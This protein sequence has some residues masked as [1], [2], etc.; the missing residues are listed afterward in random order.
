MIIKQY[1]DDGMEVRII[2]IKDKKGPK[3]TK[4][5]RAEYMKKYREQ[6]KEQIASYYQIQK[7]S[8]N[9]KYTPTGNPK[10]RPRK[11]NLENY[12]GCTDINTN[13]QPDNA[14]TQ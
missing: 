1:S 6:K 11:Y 13:S 8:G 4:E 10:G 2:Q 9:I 12:N 3:W 5:H 14:S 7:L